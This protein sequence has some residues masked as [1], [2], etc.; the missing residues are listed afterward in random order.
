MVGDRFI[1]PLQV[2]VG[3]Q[4]AQAGMVEVLAIQ[5][6]LPLMGCSDKK[7]IHI[8]TNLGASPWRLQTMWEVISYVFACCQRVSPSHSQLVAIKGLQNTEAH[9]CRRSLVLLLFFFFFLCFLSLKIG[10]NPNGIAIPP[11]FL[12]GDPPAKTGKLSCSILHLIRTCVWMAQG[13]R[14]QST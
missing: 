7:P 1:A 12:P 3:F 8:V 10:C 5:L 4:I 13:L 11:H 6:H 2:F 9:F 14:L